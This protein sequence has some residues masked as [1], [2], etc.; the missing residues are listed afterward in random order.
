MTLKVT[1]ELADADLEHFRIIMREA[2][3]VARQKSRDDI[4]GAAESLLVKVRGADVPDFVGD[5]L[6]R[7]Q[8]LVDMIRDAD[9]KL[10]V[11]ETARVLNALAYFS[12]PEDLIPDHVPGLGFLDDA[13]M[14][15]LVAREL[16]HEVDAYKDFCAFRTGEEARRRQIGEPFD[17]VTKEQYLASRRVQ[18]HKRIRNRRRGGGRSGRRGGSAGK[19]PFSLF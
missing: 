16:R 7:I 10:P 12:E 11:E 13:I 1:F 9:W 18:L 4:L 5:R 3:E 2:R 8:L 15:E 17:E 14:V 6:E 19:S